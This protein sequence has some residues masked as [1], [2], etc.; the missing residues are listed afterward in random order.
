MT[1]EHITFLLMIFFAVFLLSWAIIVPTVSPQAKAAR[2]LRS[3]ISGVINSMDD[4]AASLLRERYLRDLSG[5]ERWIESM[6][7]MTRLAGLLEQ[8]GWKIPAYRLVVISVVMG[9]AASLI[10]VIVTRQPLLALLGPLVISPLPFLKLHADRGRR[11]AK[12]EEQLP[13]A[14]DVMS[15]ALRAGHPFV[16]S[17]QMVS[18]ELHDPVASEFKTTFSDINYG[19]SV[20]NAFLGLLQRIPSMSLVAV[21]TVVLIQRETGGNMAEILDKIA[22]I[23]R[24][25]F[26]FQR[27]VRTLSAEGR[28]SAWVLSLSPFALAAMLWISSPDYLPM[29]TKDPLGRQIIAVA[30]VGTIIGIFWMRRIIRIDV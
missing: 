19:I 26:R 16:E 2:R 13:E 22:A 4:D 28:M 8:A 11:L 9:V 10:L 21:V 14:L 17:L 1:A 23:I 25:R 18:D 3:R 15:R 30:F 24:G 6:P 29:L 27:K 5:M 12:F 20:K 7:G